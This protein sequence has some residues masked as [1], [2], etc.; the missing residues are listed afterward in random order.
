MAGGARRDLGRGAGRRL[1]PG[2]ARRA[3]VWMCD[4]GAY[5]TGAGRNAAASLAAVG[6]GGGAAAAA[7]AIAGK[8]MSSW[9]AP[10][11]YVLYH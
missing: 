10:E 9:T 2:A 3:C 7:A 8:A 1:L 4:G 11:K 6:G 5:S